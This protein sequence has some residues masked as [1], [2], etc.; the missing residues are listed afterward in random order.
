MGVFAAD[1][2]CAGVIKGSHMAT[3][4][5]FAQHFTDESCLS[6]RINALGQLDAPLEQ[7]TFDAIRMLQV[8]ARTIVVLSTENSGLHQVELPWLSDNKARASLPYALEEQVAQDVT[9]LHVAFDQKHYQ[10]KH[11]LVVVIDKVFLQNLMNRLDAAS[12]RCDTITLDW[13]AL[14]A[15]ETVVS[16]TSLLIHDDVFEGALSA[17]PADIYLANRLSISPILI[18]NDSA[19][20]LKSFPLTQAVDSSYYEWIAQ[21]LL[22]TKPMNLCQGELQHNT[23]QEMNA[24]WYQATAVLAGLLV[25]SFF[26]INGFVL[27]HLTNKIVSLDQKIAVI[28]REFFPHARQVISP[29][30]RVGHLL[31]EGH[32]GQDKALWQLEDTLAT[33]IAQGEYTIEQLSYQ[34]QTLAVTLIAKDFAALDG[35]QLRLQQA[36][37]K[38]KQTQASSH[39]QQVNAILE[40]RL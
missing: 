16:E 9:S 5:L 24:R 6:L 31:K 23:K 33:A 2:S 36:G 17:E 11:Y 32:T 20:V 7:R 14:N 30:F 27:H 26:I 12:L 1:W 39:E 19:A 38:V 22:K 4:F 13:F 21:R 10:N 40:L 25:V 28:Y 34:N 37:V 18:F 8:K 35:L 29:K 15:D 3:C